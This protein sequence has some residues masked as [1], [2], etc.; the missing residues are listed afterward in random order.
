ML[1]IYYLL[2]STEGQVKCL[3]D[4]KRVLE[5]YR[6]SKPPAMPHKGIDDEMMILDALN[7]FPGLEAIDMGNSN[8]MSTDDYNNEYNDLLENLQV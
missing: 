7:D 2:H 6:A 3:P 5:E 8:G 1:T 4:K